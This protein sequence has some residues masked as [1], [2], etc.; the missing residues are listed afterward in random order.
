[1]F[2]WVLMP[3]LSETVKGRSKNNDKWL[4]KNPHCKFSQKNT[5]FQ[6]KFAIRM[7]STREINSQSGKNWLHSS[8]LRQW[9]SDRNKLQQ[10][11]FLYVGI[12]KATC[13][14]KEYTIGLRGILASIFMT[15]TSPCPSLYLQNWSSFRL[16]NK[17]SKFASLQIFY[18]IT[19]TLDR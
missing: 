7:P 10:K 13:Q 2:D 6:Q 1:M 11:K 12:W 16:T 14:A 19:G 17:S 5:L 8:S 18:P 9:Q 3:K 15:N 4:L